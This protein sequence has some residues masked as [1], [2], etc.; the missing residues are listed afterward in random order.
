MDEQEDRRQN[1][2]KVEFASISAVAVTLLFVVIGQSA[3]QLA[4]SSVV[5]TTPG[6]KVKA[7]FNAID[8]ASTGATGKAPVVIGPCATPRP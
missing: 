8:Y 6:G 5:E 1:W 7:Q 3:E 2:R 4:A